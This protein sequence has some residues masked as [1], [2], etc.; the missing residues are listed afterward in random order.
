MRR[1]NV[2][3]STCMH[4]PGVEAVEQ[5]AQWSHLEIPYRCALRCLK[6]TCRGLAD[7]VRTYHHQQHDRSCQE[8]DEK[9]EEEDRLKMG[10]FSLLPRDVLSKLLW[11]VEQREP[12]QLRVHFIPQLPRG[13]VY[14]D[15]VPLGEGHLLPVCPNWSVHQLLRTLRR[16]NILQ[17][18]FPPGD[19]LVHIEADGTI[20]EPLAATLTLDKVAASQKRIAVI[21]STWPGNSD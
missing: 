14:A 16:Q 19:R 15:A 17:G 7:V 6:Q 18:G 5:L 10:L 8:E 4:N 3:P 21:L 13:S 2:G 9:E 12:F 20:A 11:W 1:V